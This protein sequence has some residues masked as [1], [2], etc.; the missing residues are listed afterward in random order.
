M[1]LTPDAVEQ[2][3]SLADF[4][5]A[6]EIDRAILLPKGPKP[7]VGRFLRLPFACLRRDDALDLEAVPQ[8]QVAVFALG[9]QVDELFFRQDRRH[10]RLRAPGV[11][12]QDKNLLAFHAGQRDLGKAPLRGEVAVAAQ[13]H[14]RLAGAQLGV[15]RALPADTGL[16]AGM[17]V[18]VEEH[19]VVPLPGQA[20]L[21]FERS[22]SVVAA[23]ADEQVAHVGCAGFAPGG[24][25]RL[26]EPQ[27]CRVGL[28]GVAHCRSMGSLFMQASIHHG[29]PV[30]GWRRS[31][32]SASMRRGPGA[33][34][35]Q[36]AGAGLEGGHRTSWH[37]RQAATSDV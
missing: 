27:T 2:L 6:A 22:S 20:G 25:T 11:D 28:A 4:G 32:G 36:G 33:C 12:L 26:A 35:R 21:Q 18:Q 3:A 30:L 24:G 7:R 34:A 37:L 1:T 8:P 29:R 10:P 23:V 9:P 5:V 19:R 31:A 17:G 15:E 13:R 14:H 16:D